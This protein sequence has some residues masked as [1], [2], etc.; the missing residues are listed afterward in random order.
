[1]NFGS[2]G[3]HLQTSINRGYLII[4]KNTFSP[5]LRAFLNVIT[6]NL[7]VKMQINGV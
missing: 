3:D 2:G 5:P 4:Q 6:L 1:M 7:S